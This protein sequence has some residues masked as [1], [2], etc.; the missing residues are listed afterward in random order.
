MQKAPAQAGAR[1]DGIVR[2]CLRQGGE[3]LGAARQVHDQYA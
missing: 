3:T 1:G 2:Q